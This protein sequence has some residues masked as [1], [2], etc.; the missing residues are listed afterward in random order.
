MRDYLRVVEDSTGPRHR[1]ELHVGKNW[2]QLRTETIA[3][4]LQRCQRT[5]I[6]RVFYI[7]TVPS[8][9][10]DV[11]RGDCNIVELEVLHFEVEVSDIDGL[12][13]ALAENKSLVRLIFFYI[14]IS[15]DNWTVLCQSLS[16]HPKVEYLELFRTFPHVPDLHNNERKTRR[17]NSFLKMLQANTALQ[18]L[19]IPRSPSNFVNSRYNEFDERILSDVIQPYLR[20]L[21][22]VRALGNNRGPGY[23][24]LL[25]RALHKV[26]DSPALVWTLIRS[27]IP[28]ILESGEDD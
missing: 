27:S 1:I 23:D 9:I 22:H 18:E 5:I 21:P 7:E 28:T 10:L 15:D 3:E 24:Q 25:A 17:T 6:L 20:R 16:R 11:L 4:F 2:S 8:P 26:C 14:Q 19:D 13:R 12:V